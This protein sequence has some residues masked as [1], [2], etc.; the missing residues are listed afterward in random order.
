MRILVIGAGVI[1][2]TSAWALQ[3]QGHDVC[4]IERQSTAAEGTSH[5]NAGMITPGYTAPWPAP[6]IW[7]KLP[8][9]LLQS[10]TP[11]AI[12]PPLSRRDL[13]WMLASLRQCRA[14]CYTA[15][16]QA[17]MAL[18]VYSQAMMARLRDTV[19]LHYAQRFGGTLQLFRHPVSLTDLR[20]HTDYLD[21]REIPY[22][23]LDRAGCL[24]REPGLERAETPPV[25]GL[26]MPQDET[27]DCCL[28][29]R[30]LAAAF[31]AR[32]G[33]IRYD[34]PVSGLLVENGH[35]RGALDQQGEALRAE[36]VVLC[37]GH[38]TPALLAPLGLDL[39]IAALKGYSMTVPLRIP[40]YGPQS[41]VLDDTYKVALTR[42]ENTIRVGGIAEIAGGR[43]GLTRRHLETLR[44]SLA[45]LFPDSYVAEEAQ[46]WAGQRPTTPTNLPFIAETALAGL[47]VNAG[48]G[49]F[50]WT[51]AAG[52]A[53]LLADLVS[54][55]PSPISAAPYR[56]RK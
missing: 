5:A 40:A 34:T 24:A 30:Q 28:F 50:G 56:V 3:E 41:T 54:G 53:A 51:M 42:L 1:G 20:L 7:R 32:G 49:T 10:H 2:T 48:H 38:E 25:S 36:R 13:R 23:V 21:Q 6:K 35:V 29:T 18:S 8:R 55:T 37:T 47:Y 19:P 52:A 43:Q 27:G 39:P 14:R 15:N 44:L 12:S 45:S 16:I 4:L 46:F 22:E 31:V 17:M 9:W 11:F 33:E 26:Y